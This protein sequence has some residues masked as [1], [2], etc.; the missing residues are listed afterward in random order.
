[1]RKI[2]TNAL[3]GCSIALLNTE[4]VLSPA[5]IRVKTVA[6]YRYQPVMSPLSPYTKGR[7]ELKNKNAIAMRAPM[8]LPKALHCD[9]V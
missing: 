7:I 5:M 1:M 9:F 6:K 8:G 2:H 4:R 3:S